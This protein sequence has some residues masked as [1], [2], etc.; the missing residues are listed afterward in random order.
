MHVVLGLCAPDTALTYCVPWHVD[1]T[2]LRPMTA[3][4]VSGE[5]ATTTVRRVTRVGVVMEQKELEQFA[6]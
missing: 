5:A 4:A 6:S 1:E 2:E 3:T